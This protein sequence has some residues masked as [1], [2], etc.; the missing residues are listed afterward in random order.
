MPTASDFEEEIYSRWERAGSSGATY[1]DIQAGDLHRSLGGYPGPNHRIPDCCQ[2][3]R[4]L[5]RAVDQVLREPP[6]GTGATLLIRYVLS[7]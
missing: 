7:R 4:R 1:V 5:M 2:V 6:Q 3:M